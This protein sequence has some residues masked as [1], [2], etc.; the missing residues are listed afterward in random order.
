MLSSSSVQS[1]LHDLQQS[2][3]LLPS[4]V[5]ISLR[6]HSKAAPNNTPQN[7]C[8]SNQQRECRQNNPHVQQ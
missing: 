6:L 4:K 2:L 7:D 5:L 8:R 3:H 1:C